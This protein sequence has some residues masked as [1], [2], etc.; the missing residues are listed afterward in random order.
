MRS[1]VKTSNLETPKIAFVDA[2]Q[3]VDESIYFQRM[4]PVD[5]IPRNASSPQ[6][7][8]KIY[9]KSLIP[10]SSKEKDILRGY[11]NDIAKWVRPYN[12]LSNIPW[13]FAK[14]TP[15]IEN[16]YPHTLQDVIILSDRFFSA[17]DQIKT[18]IHEKIHVYQRMY[19]LE[20]NKLIHDVWGFEVKDKMENHPMARNNPDID[21][22]VY[23]KKKGM[24]I[25]LYT[26]NRPSSLADSHAYLL[27]GTKKIDLTHIS[28]LDIHS[29]DP[30]IQLE[31]PY[32]IMACVLAH[33]LSK[34]DKTND[35]M[36]S[37][38]QRYL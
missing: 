30:Y 35:A 14:V 27:E 18:L 25:Q 22:F 3:C 5:L 38:M 23:G 6:A 32:E 36:L 26:T 13:K 9:K 34:E 19:P 28:Q 4:T 1:N 29:D 37:W 16:G 20:T 2:N 12:N 15:D 33:R 8:A 31:H 10:F 21:G 11:V 7:Y 24:I 17:S